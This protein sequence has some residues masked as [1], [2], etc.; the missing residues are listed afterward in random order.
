MV[1]DILCGKLKDFG[2]W[3]YGVNQKLLKVHPSLPLS[4]VVFIEDYKKKHE[5]LFTDL[6]PFRFF[7]CFHLGVGWGLIASTRSLRINVPLYK[8][9]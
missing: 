4:L 7:F 8:L 6:S 3:R 2:V 9:Q 1:E 5:T